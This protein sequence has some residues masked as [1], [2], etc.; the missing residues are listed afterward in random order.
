MTITS[1][2]DTRVSLEDLINSSNRVSAVIE[3]VRSTM[4]APDARKKAPTFTTSQVA[5]ICGI[6]KAAIDYR[7]KKGDLPT[8]QMDDGRRRKFS[9]ADARAWAQAYRPKSLRPNNAEAITIA[10]ANFKGGVTKTTTAVT[11]AQGLSLRGHKVLVIDT[12]P[13]GSMTTLFGLLPDVDVPDEKTILGLCYGSELAVDYAISPT[14]WSGIDIVPANLA[15]YSAE[16]ALPSR[17]KTEPNFEFWNVLNNGI[18]VARTNYDVIIL[19]TSPSL[20]YLT[21]NALLASDGLIMPL[22]PSTLDFTSSG[23]FWNLFNDL[24]ANLLTNRGKSKSFD[25]VDVLLARV[26]ANDSSS[27]VVREWITAGYANM[28]LPVEIPKTSLT[29]SASAEFGTVYDTEPSSINARTYRRAYD[30]YERV[31]ELVEGQIQTAWKR[32]I[33]A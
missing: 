16:F 6:E 31:V 10:V 21:I 17:Q 23:Q 22:P 24:A 26:D 33:G 25:F 11:L 18:D 8:G 7:I 1:S 20:S 14:Y 12:D 4:L 3:S 32:Q 27:S 13:Q 15:L 2:K 9:L 30:A 5:A 19:D 29:A 28:V